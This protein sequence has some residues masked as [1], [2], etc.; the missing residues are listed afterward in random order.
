MTSSTD[1]APLITAMEARKAIQNV[2]RDGS[3]QHGT[4]GLCGS[5]DA[6][7]VWMGA[8]SR[9]LASSCPS[10]CLRPTLPAKAFCRRP[11]R[12]WPSGADTKKPYKAILN[13]LAS[14]CEHARA[15]TSVEAFLGVGL[16]GRP[17]ACDPM[18]SWR[19]ENVATMC[20]ELYMS[21]H[22]DRKREIGNLMLSPWCEGGSCRAGQ[23]TEPGKGAMVPL[24]RLVYS[25]LGSG[26]VWMVSMPPCRRISTLF[27]H[28]LHPT[29]PC[30]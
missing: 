22:F 25:S 8:M 16:G 11:T 18:T 7:V 3:G 24:A 2:N 6:P 15:L 21:G 14:I 19:K 13:A 17:A 29:Y 28:R 27:Q 9:L 5:Y 20:H 30:T 12:T 10:L 26:M 23:D 1:L 4:R